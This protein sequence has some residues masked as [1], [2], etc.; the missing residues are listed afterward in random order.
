MKDCEEYTFLYRNESGIISV[1]TNPVFIA[2]HKDCWAVKKS[3]GEEYVSSLIDRSFE[4]H[5]ART[6]LK[7]K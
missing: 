2:N 3:L 4:E 6:L 5:K 7:D 1:T